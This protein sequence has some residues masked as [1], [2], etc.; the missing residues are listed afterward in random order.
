MDERCLGSETADQESFFKRLF[1]SVLGIG[2]VTVNCQHNQQ[3]FPMDFHKGA[4]SVLQYKNLI[5]ISKDKL[6][7]KVYCWWANAFN[8][9]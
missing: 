6:F 9:K 3:T 1:M 8:C 4:F 2:D 5:Y 7:L